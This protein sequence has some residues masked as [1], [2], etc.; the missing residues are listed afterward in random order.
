MKRFVMGLGLL[1][2]LL[3]W[4]AIGDGVV[5]RGAAQKKQGGAQPP[6]V[7]EPTVTDLLEEPLEMK[8]FQLPMTLKEAL[9]L[10]YERLA[11]KGKELPILIDT[12][13]FKGTFPEGTDL[14]DTPVKFPPFPRKMSVAQVLNLVLSKI[15]SGNATYLARQ[16]HIEIT[17]LRYAAPGMRTVSA[18]FVN[19]PVAEALG[20]LARQSGISIVLDGRVAKKAQ[21][22]VTVTFPPNTNLLLAVGLLADLAGLKVHALDR[23]VFVTDRDHLDIPRQERAPEKQ[24][25]QGKFDN[26]PLR[27]V[28]AELAA[29]A[30]VTILVDPRVGK[31]ADKT[32]NATFHDG[33]NVVTAATLLA[34]M[35]GLKLVVANRILYVTAPTNDAKI[36]PPAPRETPGEFREGGSPTHQL[37][38]PGK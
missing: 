12:E 21:V 29:Q 16:D 33:A 27:E 9:G 13:A 14:Y 3:G 37:K 6:E 24:A 15:P 8:Y 11:T 25:V 4:V 26:Q 10:I 7:N 36:L 34:D 30:N 2:L 31:K 17:T 28:L 32:I 18:R 1:A 20:N 19:R 38:K 23:L 22:P 5:A 35:A